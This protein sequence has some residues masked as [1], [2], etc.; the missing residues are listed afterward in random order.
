MAARGNLVLNDGQATPVAHTFNP[1]SGD[2][3]VPGTSVI[4]YE[5][6]VSGVNAGFPVIQ[7]STRQPTKQNRN[8][9][10]S[11]WFEVP[12]LESVTNSTVTG[13]APAPQSA[14]K[15]T[16][17]VSFVLPDRSVAAVRKDLLAYVRNGLANA[18]V[19]SAIHDLESPW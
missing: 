19:T 14:Y 5:D 6:R 12:V 15:V 16:C 17:L 3:N 1:N 18:V 4:T 10:V 11:L 7:I 13:I 2:G 8:R 9:K